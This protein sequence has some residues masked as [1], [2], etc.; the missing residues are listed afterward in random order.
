MS[1]KRLFSFLSEVKYINRLIHVHIPYEND[2]TL[3]DVLL[4]KMKEDEIEIGV[5]ALHFTFL[6]SVCASLRIT[7]GKITRIEVIRSIQ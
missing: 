3:L 6:I 2:E 5:G 4:K 1:L 7:D